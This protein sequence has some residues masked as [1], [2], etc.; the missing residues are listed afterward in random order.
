MGPLH[1][2]LD[3]LRRSLQTGIRVVTLAVMLRRGQSG[4]A[5]S[6][7]YV[8]RYGTTL[9]CGLTEQRAVITRALENAI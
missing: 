5:E 9:P 7:K 1:A 2:I 6:K 8:I 3:P 4:L